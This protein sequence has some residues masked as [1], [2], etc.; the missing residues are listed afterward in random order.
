MYNLWNFF[1]SR[2]AFTIL[3]M[4]SLLIAGAYALFAIPKESTPEVIIPIGVV[5][6]VLPGATAA[7]VEQLVTDKL[8]P[9]V[10]NVA[11]IDKV[12]SSSRPG[13]S[14]ITAQFIASADI[15]TAIQDLRNAVEGARR[16]LPSDAEVPTVTKVD[17][18]D[19][20]ILMLGIGTDLAPE[21]LTRLGDDL[22]DD[23][24]SVEGV[25]K[26]EV[27]GTRGR[28]IS[29]IVHKEK[30]AQNS[31]RVEQVI[32]ALRA[33]NASAP[34]GNITVSGID[35]PIQF[36]GAITDVEAVKNTPLKTPT[37]EITVG[38]IATVVDG[39]EKPNSL[40][41]IQ[42]AGEESQFALSLFIYKSSGG[43][44]LE[45]S[46]R[47]KKRLEELEHTTLAGSSAVITYDAADEVRTSISE[48]STSGMQT[49]AL[50]LLVLFIAIGFKD[51]LVAA[52]AI[53][54]SFMIAFVGMWVTGNTINF[55][56]LFSLIIAIGILVDSG[57]VVVE[58]FHT[59]RSLGMER[60]AAA[61]KVLKDFSWPLIAGTATTVAVFIPLFFLSGIIGQFIKSIPFTIV[62]VLAASIVVAL[63]F[64]PSI[65]LHLIKHE[66]SPL[67]QK[68]ER[69]WAKI[70]AWYRKTMENFFATRKL[71][72]LFYG[73]LTISFLGAFALPISGALKVA[74]FPP[75]DY[76]LFYI[77]IEL[78]QAT[79][80]KET[81][82][83]ARE[84]EE[85]VATTPYLKSLVTTVGATSA[86]NSNGSGNG[87]KYANITVNLEKER[88]G[89]NS[90]MLT[91]DLRN[92]LRSYDFG[93]AKVSVFDA[94][95]GPPSGA[96][97]V[98]KIWGND[99]DRLALATEMVERILESTPGTRDITSSLANDGTELVIDIDR[100]K[101][102]EYGL[103]TADIAS[104]LRTAVAGTEATKVRIDGDDVEVR[105][106]FDLNTE[107]TGPEDTTIATADDIREIPIP[108]ARGIV[109]LGSLTTIKADRTSAVIGHENGIRIGNVSSY[110]TED[111]NAIEVT[112][113]IRTEA[114]KL[115]LPEGVR[116]TYGGDDEEIKKTFTEM[117]V[118]LLAGLVLMFA[119]LVLEFDTFTR[120]L[121]LLSAIPLSLTGVLW[122]LFI[123]GQPLSFTAFLGIIALAGVIINHGILLLDAMNN[124]KKDNPDI[125]PENLVL[126]TAES[127]VRPILLT[128]VTTVIGMIPLTIVSEM[129]APLAF[130][131]AFGL[132]YG[133]LLT[134]VFIPLLSYRRELKRAKKKSVTQ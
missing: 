125:S 121:R 107:F 34:A 98:V 53:P 100:E 111:A 87:A 39:F 15:D 114:E 28:Q 116:L 96:P 88:H 69:L 25:S 92:E 134:L 4:V 133:T 84:V 117:L 63:G 11:N 21:T 59:N 126:D 19:Q 5:T 115:D 91:D 17:F 89:V 93:N 120:S 105:V 67:A 101:A 75:S 79:T 71:Q 109:P 37:G 124:R 94:E 132:L 33:T 110:V 55:V 45:V 30:L 16:E 129:W 49:V 12:T 35:Y 64:V 130:T 47:V 56:S 61:R 14:I 20:P 31:I 72:W 104:T 68:R 50:V 97:I 54:F 57:I 24:I 102:N 8:E 7:D 112:N 1:L 13:A 3:T 32:N 86:F 127:R 66:H 74:M 65:T 76:D 9:A 51:A 43:S 36:E 41:R 108:T 44:I 82:T 119:I 6:T 23:L 29:V 38:D 73:F 26:V 27:S 52:L 131:I 103:A 85:I 40:S 122:G 70:G 83:V 113:A 48:L 42:E 58:G 106:M 123:A 78:P 10:R 95:G 81:D 99:T 80:L 128:T 46:D 118:A 22:Q 2:R 60:Y 62:V 90:L 18:Q 77:E